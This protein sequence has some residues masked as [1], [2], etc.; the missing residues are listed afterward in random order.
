MVTASAAEPLMAARSD[1]KRA[2]DLL[3]APTPQAL[4]DCQ[5][6]LEKATDTLRQW[7]ARGEGADR[8]G[9]HIACDLR[10]EVRRAGHLLEGLATFYTGWE[11]IL[12]A[13]SGGYTASGNP[14]PL[15]RDGRLCFR[16]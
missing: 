13:L 11:R 2:C 3:V 7:H 10:A 12:G 9:R 1:V 15:E 8:T 4:A 6:A 14:A 5:Q 16:G